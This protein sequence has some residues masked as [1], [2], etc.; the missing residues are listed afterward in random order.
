MG[1]RD[2]AHDASNKVIDGLFVAG[3][4][5]DLFPSPYYCAGLGNGFSIAS[6]LLAGERAGKLVKS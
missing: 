5:A 4:D 6:G 3:A 1:C 2:D